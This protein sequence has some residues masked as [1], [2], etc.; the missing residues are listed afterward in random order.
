MFIILFQYKFLFLI[1]NYDVMITELILM[2]STT[3]KKE[4]INDLE[5]IFK[6]T[7]KRF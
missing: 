1:Q 4:S 3:L 5:I 2:L 6:V 7:L